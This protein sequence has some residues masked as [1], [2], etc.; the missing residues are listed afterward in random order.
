[1]LEGVGGLSLEAQ[2]SPGQGRMYLPVPSPCLHGHGHIPSPLEAPCC[3]LWPLTVKAE[4]GRC[5]HSGP[6]VS[7]GLQE[8]GGLHRGSDR[9]LCTRPP[10]SSSP[11]PGD[12]GAVSSPIFHMEKLRPGDFL[13]RVLLEV[14]EP[15]FWVCALAFLDTAGQGLKQAAPCSSGG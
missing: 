7:A 10:A 6:P 4:G 8:L 2:G 12:R 9:T 15:G 1:M 5:Q 3:P 14:A 13:K 11:W